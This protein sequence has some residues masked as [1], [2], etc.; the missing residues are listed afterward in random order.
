MMTPDMVRATMIETL[1]GVEQTAER[2]PAEMAS[3]VQPQAQAE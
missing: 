3:P 2:V 1:Q